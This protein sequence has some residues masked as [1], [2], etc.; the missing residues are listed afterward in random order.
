MTAYSLLVVDDSV[1]MR[2]ALKRYL[3][4]LNAEIKEAGNGKEG[5]QQ[6]LVNDLDLIITDIDM[7]GMD[8]IEFCLQ[9]KSNPKTRNI[10]VI[11]QSSF[12]SETDIER[13]FQAG[14]SKYISKSEAKD[15]L[16]DAIRDILSHSNPHQ[17]KQIMVV[18]DSR[19]IRQ[20]L[21]RG[22]TKAGFQ[23]IT[24]ENGR[25]ALT[26]IQKR[27]PDLILSDIEMPVMDGFAFCKA[28][29]ADPDLSSIPFIVMS[30]NQD[31]NNMK[32]MLKIGA[33]TYITKPFNIDHLILLVEKFLFD[34][35]RSLLKE[36]QRLDAERNLILSSITSLVSALE[37]RDAYTKGHSEC[38]AEILSGMAKHMRLDKVEIERLNIGGRLHDIG[39]IGIRD[40]ILLKTGKLTAEE[41]DHIKQHPVIGANILK[42]IDSLA[43]IVSIVLCHH[44]RFD[45]KGYPSGL[46]GEKIPLKARMTAVADT[47][48]AL[49]TDRPYRK[50]MPHDKAIAIIESA[51]GTQ[52]C[53]ECVSIFIEW[54]SSQKEKDFL[55][56][57]PSLTCKVAQK[58]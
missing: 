41:F 29:H 56:F 11:I 19:I 2:N 7:P 14:A 58:L 53:P 22:L 3:Y 43:D 4:P 57:S 55:L 10:P 16:L 9:L 39:K 6:V 38:V 26:L 52:L 37:A 44:E 54:I 23:I 42:S 5:L 8:G 48:N 45:G 12:D 36:K 17:S 27:Q 49:T 25:Q 50:G 31:R 33:E 18:D 1:A 13:G 35:Y 32:N 34:Q 21:E 40:S 46:K 24:A 30:S 47:Y 51:S 15:C 20:M 28:V